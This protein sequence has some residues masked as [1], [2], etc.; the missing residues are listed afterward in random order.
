MNKSIVIEIKKI[1]NLILRTLINY[2]KKITD[3]QLSPVQIAI[4]KYLNQNKDNNVNQKD[5][6]EFIQN[7]K[8]TI[9]CI[10]DNMQKNNIIERV[11]SKSDGR[12]KYIKLTQKGFDLAKK[13]SD[14]QIYFDNMISKN[15]SEDDLETFF[16]VTNQIKNNLKGEEDD[17]TI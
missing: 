7:R 1:D 6:E 11:N 14:Q 5:L 15:I 12:S 17:K 16:K 4:I 9:S 8:S 13:F 2:S 10:L 3:I